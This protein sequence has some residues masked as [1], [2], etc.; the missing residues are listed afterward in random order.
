MSKI[1]TRD[2]SRELSDLRYDNHTITVLGDS[3]FIV[4]IIGEVHIQTI[5]DIFRVD[6]WKYVDGK[7]EFY[8]S[9]ALI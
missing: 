9:T 8:I 7:V 2:I 5:K 1:N 6:S 3:K 4:R